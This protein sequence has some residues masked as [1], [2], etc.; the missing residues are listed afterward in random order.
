MITVFRNEKFSIRKAI[1]GS[2][3]NNCYIIECTVTK[4]LIVID[5]PIGIGQVFSSLDVSKIKYLL[6]T[7]GHFDHI[8]GLAEIRSDLQ[9][10]VIGIDNKDAEALIVDQIDFL[11]NSQ[12]VKN[13]ELEIK[14]L[15]TPGHTFGSV[16]F[17]LNDHLFS[18]DTLFPG[19]PGRTDS[20]PSFECILD[21]IDTKIMNLS[22][23]TQIH[24][25]HGI[26]ANLRNEKKQY[27][28]FIQTYYPERDNVYGHVS[29]TQR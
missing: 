8:D 1:L 11:K 26:S 13:G 6:I 7:H 17:L 5:A 22:E 9:N 2:F 21:S 24:P 23:S 16:C 3:E 25:G 20:K 18:G 14:V 10:V 15:S 27:L 4:S 28:G 12:I 29:W 19:G